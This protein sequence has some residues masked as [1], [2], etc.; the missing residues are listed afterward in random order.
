MSLS[1]LIVENL[2]KDYGSLRAVDGV[3]FSLKPGE[4]FGL[5]GPNGAGKTSVISTIVTLEKPTSGRV[6]VFG[7]D[8]TQEPRLAKVRVGLVP[9]ELV[10]HGYFNIEEVLSFHSGYYGI[11][12][13]REQEQ[14]LLKRLALWDHRHKR[15]KQLSGGMK[16]RLLIA[17]ALVHRPKLLLLD[18]PT[19]GVDI[20]L[21]ATLWDFVKELREQGMTIL[22]TTHYLEEAER[23]CDRVGMIHMGRLQRLG[24]TADLITEFT[25]RQVRLQFKGALRDFNH[26]LL[27]RQEEQVVEFRVPYHMGLGDLLQELQV[28]LNAIEDLKIEEGNLEDVFRQVIGGHL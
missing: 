2:V 21:R 25:H 7:H 12:N 20:E 19:A 24:N 3:S 10:N 5:L 16:R 4:I 17:K 15:V 27:I 8:V 6:Q 18:E 28:E 23:L 22:L 14:Y 26:P 13:N 9:Q 1:P 11:R